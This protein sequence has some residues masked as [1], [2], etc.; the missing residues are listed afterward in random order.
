MM[1][2]LVIGIY[3]RLSSLDRR[4]ADRDIKLDVADFFY[5]GGHGKNPNI[6]TLRICGKE[7]KPWSV[8]V[9]THRC[10]NEDF[11][12]FKCHFDLSTR[13]F[14]SLGIL[15][16]LMILGIPGKIPNEEYSL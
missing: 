16:S 4:K 15:F 5:R 13:R 9:I 6:V 11:A 8:W 2:Y 12:V 3:E 10:P 14:I 7:K 1:D